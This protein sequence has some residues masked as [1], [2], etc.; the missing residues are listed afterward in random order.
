MQAA[1]VNMY[2]LSQFYIRM[3]QIKKKACFVSSHAFIQP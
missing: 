2:T 1:Y 3:L